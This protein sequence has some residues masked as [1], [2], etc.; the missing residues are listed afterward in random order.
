MR[1]RVWLY[2]SARRCQF[3]GRLV[4][5]VTTDI[6]DQHASTQAKMPR[7]SPNMQPGQADTSSIPAPCNNFAY[8]ANMVACMECHA[9][10]PETQRKIETTI[11]QPAKKSKHRMPAASKQAWLLLTLTGL[12]LLAWA[13]LLVRAHPVQVPL[14]VV[15]LLVLNPC[16]LCK[17]ICCWEGICNLLC[18]CHH[19]T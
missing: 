1:T 19:L 9:G 11:L 2:T 18:C 16:L 14:Q 10:A 3:V 7:M 17:L 5:E 15:I 6:Y 4:G 13:R 8:Q 12:V